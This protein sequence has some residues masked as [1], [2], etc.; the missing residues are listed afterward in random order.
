[1]LLPLPQEL[2]NTQE[3]FLCSDIAKWLQ[4]TPGVI[5]TQFHVLAYTPYC[6]VKF[7]VLTATSTIT[8]EAAGPSE[9]SMHMYWTN[10]LH[11]LNISKIFVTQSEFSL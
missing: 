4:V 10:D 6:N 7:E 9:T 3:V 1:M 11:T 5:T 2:L 8:M